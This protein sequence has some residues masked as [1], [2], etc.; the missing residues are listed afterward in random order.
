[1]ESGF[2]EKSVVDGGGGKTGVQFAPAA[3]YVLFDSG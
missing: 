3:E 2:L 1:M